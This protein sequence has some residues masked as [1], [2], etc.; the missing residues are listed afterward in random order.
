MAHTQLI[1]LRTGPGTS[2]ARA[3]IP[4]SISVTLDHS[5]P[6]DGAKIPVLPLP[7]RPSQPDTANRQAGNARGKQQKGAAGIAP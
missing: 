5:D 4:A 6:T 3:A 1:L 7:V 2:W